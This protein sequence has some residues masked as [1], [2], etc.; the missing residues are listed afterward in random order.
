MS[1]P[2]GVLRAEM[3]LRV[4]S[5][6]GMPPRGSFQDRVIQ[7]ML[8]RERRREIITQTYQAQLVAAGLRIHP[9]LF[10]LW[11]SM[12][13]DEVSH[14]NYK[15]RVVAQ[16]KEMLKAFAK[17][18]K[19]PTDLVAKASKLTVRRKEDLKPYSAAELEG[20]KAK[21]RRRTIAA[22]QR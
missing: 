8:I 13:V 10:D 11:T 21:L 6:R 18:R 17:A 2:G 22:A 15:P 4:M 1:T 20:I 5:H 3:S 9:A 7:E 14:D 12:Y 16:K 19:V